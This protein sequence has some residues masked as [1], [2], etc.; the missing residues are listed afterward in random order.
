MKIGFGFC[1]FDDFVKVLVKIVV[2]MGVLGVRFCVEVLFFCVF[3]VG[4]VAGI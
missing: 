2:L 1:F 4:G 3:V